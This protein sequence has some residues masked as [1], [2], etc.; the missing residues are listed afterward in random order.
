MISLTRL[1]G[2]P[3]VI[4]SDLIKSI[5]A[6]PDTL[7]TLIHGEKLVVLESCEEVVQRISQY[8]VRLLDEMAAGS[9]QHALSAAIATAASAQRASAAAR[10]LEPERDEIISDFGAAQ[11]RRI[12]R[13]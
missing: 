6:S 2:H 12:S 13:P 5:E 10:E 4:N 3:I 9:A 8:R 11:R 1:N 7:L